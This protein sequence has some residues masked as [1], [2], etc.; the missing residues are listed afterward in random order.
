VTPASGV[1]LAA[2][3]GRP[4]LALRG[5]KVLMYHRLVL[6]EAARTDKYDVLRSSFTGCLDAVA[7]GGHD[8]LPLAAL[9]RSHGP[10]SGRGVV[11]S[12]DDGRSSDYEIA[13][14]ELAARGLRAELFISPSRIGQAGFLTWAQVR[15][16]DRCG[17]SFQSHSYDHVALPLLSSSSLVS[18]LRESKREIEDRTGRG[19][20]FLAAPY[21]LV[22]RRVIEAAHGEGYLG[23]ADFRFLRP[24]GSP[25]AAV[26][27]LIRR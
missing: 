10:V 11:V 24:D 1:E 4:R 2:T 12:F 6:D 9:Y 18:Q 3:A 23:V 16:M 26:A 25:E 22:S 21:G 7:R 14:P 17:L 5:V 27:V 19:V 8:V 15:E 13:F 20:D